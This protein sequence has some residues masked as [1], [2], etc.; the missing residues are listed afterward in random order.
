[1]VVM[2]ECSPAVV[3]RQQMDEPIHDFILVEEE[4][5]VEETA[6]FEVS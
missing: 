5:Q 4:P 2:A 1:M 3:D 6:D